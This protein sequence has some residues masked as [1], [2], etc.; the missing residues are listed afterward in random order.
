ME[1]YKPNDKFNNFSIS[2][3][4]TQAVCYLARG[5][6]HDLNNLLAA[7]A[8]YCELAIEEAEEG[9]PPKRRLGLALEA[10]N[11]AKEKVRQ[12]QTFGRQEKTEAKPFDLNRTI[13]Q[14]V[15]NFKRNLPREFELNT[16]LDPKI[17]ALLGDQAQIRLLLVKLAAHAGKTLGHPGKVTFSSRV[18]VDNDFPS[19][20]FATRQSE[21]YVLISLNYPGIELSSQSR[22]HI[23]EP[24]H[25][26]KETGGNTGLNLALAWGITK[27][28]GGEIFFSCSKEG[29]SLFSIYLPGIQLKDLAAN[30]ADPNHAPAGQKG[31]QILWVDTNTKT[32]NLAEQLL[33]SEE[34]QFVGHASIDRALA[35]HEKSWRNI[36]LLVLDFNQLEEEGFR[37]IENIL[38]TNSRAK[39]M[40][41]CPYAALDRAKPLLNKGVS[42]VLKRPFL[43]ADLLTKIR[44]LMDG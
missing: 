16:E 20:P 39:I 44:T 23:F 33:S 40:L 37:A 8:G 21:K 18:L 14:A 10:A 32:K 29:E 31:R 35:V 25:P 30:E 41:T 42:E 26:L 13:L 2:A 3:E 7:V 28:H 38:K 12:L 27:A 22:Q 15:P 1:K 4:T 5:I 9:R 36:G 19:L 17:E 43:K 11:R 34:Y 24:Y 6:A